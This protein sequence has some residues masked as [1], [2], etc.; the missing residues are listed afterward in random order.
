[1]QFRVINN[2]R[3]FIW[4]RYFTSS[5]NHIRTEFWKKKKKEHETLLIVFQNSL[6]LIT[7][8]WKKKI[9][10][11]VCEGYVYQL[12]VMSVIPLKAS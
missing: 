12:Y 9:L 6:C 3:C 10:E 11:E 8:M 2:E 4:L 5:C 7:Q 1:M